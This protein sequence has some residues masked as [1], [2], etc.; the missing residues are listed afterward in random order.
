M[1]LNRQRFR[2]N[3]YSCF[4]NT[5]KKVIVGAAIAG[6]IGLVA[7]VRTEKGKGTEASVPSADSTAQKGKQR[8][9]TA[10]LNKLYGS[11]SSELQRRSICLQALD[12]GLI[13]RTGPISAVDEIF[14][15][16][17][18][19]ELPTKREARKTAVVDFEMQV[20]PREKEMAEAAGHKGW[21][22]AIEYDYNGEIQNYYLTN[23]HK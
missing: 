5:A 10:D 9:S 15:T 8:M 4:G 14:G 13:F 20:Q 3:D 7:C 12:S 2:R 17:F 19:K 6:F 22:L 23:L 18:A 21:F 11:A 1:I 16:N